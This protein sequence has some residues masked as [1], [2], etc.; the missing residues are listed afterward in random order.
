[1]N[2]SIDKKIRKTV[3]KINLILESKIKKSG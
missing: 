2:L 3:L 1:M